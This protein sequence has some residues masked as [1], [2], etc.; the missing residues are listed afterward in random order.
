MLAWTSC[1]INS[2]VIGDL[3]R[4]DSYIG[5]LVQ[6]RR[7]S[8]AL[9]MELR[10]SCTNPSIWRPCNTHLL[11]SSCRDKGTSTGYPVPQHSRYR[12]AG[13]PPGF[14]SYHDLSSASS[15]IHHSSFSC[16]FSFWPAENHND[17]VTLRFKGWKIEVHKMTD[18]LQMTFSNN[19]CSTKCIY[20]YIYICINIHIYIYIYID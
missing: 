5:G 8:S 20:I 4:H 6:E 18:N 16:L 1:G 9:A 14:P 3:I 2:L 11:H 19:S 15:H 10:L 7:N 12:T 13:T 17:A